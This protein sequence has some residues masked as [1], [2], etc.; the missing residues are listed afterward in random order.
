MLWKLRAE[1]CDDALG[2]QL[3]SDSALFNVGAWEEPRGHSGEKG[4]VQVQAGTALLV[5]VI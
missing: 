3:I 4:T 2:V 5:A 1:V